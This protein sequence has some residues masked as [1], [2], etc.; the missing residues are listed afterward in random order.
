MRNEE[1]LAALLHEIWDAHFS[2]VKKKNNVVARWKG[3]WKNKFGHIRML[4][5]K[6]TE[7]GINFLFKDE[8]VPKF[9]VEL[10][11]AHELVHYMH[12]FHSPYP[13]QFKHPH[14]GGVVD[15]ELRLRGYS[16]ELIKEKL[17]FKEEW[18]QLRKGLL[19]ETG[20]THVRHVGNTFRFF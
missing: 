14:K 11:L 15:K 5:N 6:D 13:K 16:N 8:R 3:E 20:R 4:K 17:W 1:W 10:T 18:T 12:G 9:I 7:I 19:N 2:E